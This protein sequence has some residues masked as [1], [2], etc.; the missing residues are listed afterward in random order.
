MEQTLYYGGDIITMRREGEMAEAMLTEGRT[1]RY[2]GTRAEAERLCRPDCKIADLKGCALLPG[3]IDPHGHITL[4]AQ[5]ASFADLSGCADFS[6]IV[7]KL[8]EYREENKVGEAGIIFGYGYDHNF[9]AEGKHPDRF[10]LDKVSGNIPVFIFH[11]SGHMGV[12]NSALLA[13]AGITAE[14]ADPAGGHLGRVPGE[15]SE[16][17]RSGAGSVRGACS[18]EAG[19]EK[20]EAAE[21]TVP[22]GYVEESAAIG[23][24]LGKVLGRMQVDVPLQ[25]EKA[26]SMYL[27][28]GFTTVQDGATEEGS[29]AM[30]NQMAEQGKL[31][32]DVVAYPLMT[33]DWR[34]L[35]REY[36]QY[37]NG[38]GSLWNADGTGQGSFGESQ[39]KGQPYH[40]HLRIGGLK[41]I[42]DGSPQG[43]SAWLTEPYEGGREYC[44]YPAME[45]SQA[46]RL[47]Q[48]AVD[49]N[50]Q[51]LAHCNGDAAAGQF[52]RYYEKALANSANPRKRELRPTMIHCQAVRR[53]QL[54][55][56]AKLH[57]IPSI[58]VD[59][60][61][62]WGDIHLKNLGKERGSRIS[63]VRSAIDAG[64]PVNLHQ[65]TPVVRPNALHSIWSAV[66]RET[67]NGQQLAREECC[68]AYEAL[69]AVTANAAYAYFE[70]GEKGTLEPGKLADFVILGENPL[71]VPKQHLKDIVV[72]ATIKEG[73]AVYARKKSNQESRS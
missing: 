10:V 65:D 48:E 57:M 27:E 35:L 23:M 25:M 47:C 14:T 51:L 73:E 28:Q 45:G 3:F 30:L 4:A 8:A 54:K 5:F 67:R 9:L 11:S 39:S 71:K 69:Q 40:N 49:G 68:T 56:M 61:Y 6:D 2:V 59:H 62:Y 34:K 36:P 38:I 19:M 52:L 29:M 70:E 46:G 22:D 21:G 16:A 31:R 43:K 63:P 7:D 37:Q 20:P 72:M 55:K 15:C 64:L 17:G 24:V 44:G 1:I 12:A 66:N 33:V 50:F 58:F 13:L 42:L 53:D 60:V 18:L 26:Q 41:I 32:V